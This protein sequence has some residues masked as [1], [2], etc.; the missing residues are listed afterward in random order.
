V[1]GVEGRRR[2]SSVGGKGPGGRPSRVGAAAPWMVVGLFTLLL[3]GIWLGFGSGQG[4]HHPD[5]RPEI[6]GV[7]VI[8]ASRYVGYARVSAVY[9]QAAEIAA[10][11]DGLYCY[12][13]CSR[14]SG[15]RSLLTC[16]ESDHGAA[17]DVCLTEAAIASRMTK[18]GRSLDEIR[19][20]IDELYGG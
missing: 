19:D 7:T 15:H 14:H 12:C 9:A 3:G 13:D 11:L 16:F 2:K 20:A 6:T 8:P 18:D 4:G 1:Y 17:C 10:I 5:P